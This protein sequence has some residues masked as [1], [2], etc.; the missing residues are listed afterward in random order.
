MCHMDS[1]DDNIICTLLLN[2]HKRKCTMP[3]IISDLLYLF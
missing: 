2:C 1:E 3:Q